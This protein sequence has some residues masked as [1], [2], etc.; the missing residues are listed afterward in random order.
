MAIRSIKNFFVGKPLETWQ[1]KQ[2]KIPKWKALAVFSSD[3]LS[4]VAY[5]TQE[6]LMALVVVSIAA[7]NWSLPIGLAIA[8]LLVVVSTSYSQ[9]IRCYPH[10]G[11]AYVVVRENLGTY[12]ALV[13]AAA[14]LIDYVLTVAVSAAAGVE[15]ITSA[16]PVLYGHRV[17]LGCIA[18][19][20][21]TTINLRG[22]RESAAVFA[23]PTYLFIFSFILLIGLGFWKL[24]AGELTARAPVFHETYSTIAPFLILK[25]FASGCA[26]LT[27]IEAISDGVPSFRPPEAR[28]ARITLFWMVVILGSFFL[29][30]TTLA[31]LFN[32]FPH[33]TQK[34]TVISQLGRLVFG[35]GG[36]YYVL[37]LS[38]ALIL[39]MAANTSFADFP[40]V[41]SFLGRDRFLPRQFGSLGDRLVFSNGIFILGFMSALLIIFFEGTTHKLIPLY[42][43]GVFL[44]FTF[45]Q[46]AM[47]RYQWREREKGWQ[48]SLLLSLSGAVVTAVVFSV[49][50]ITKFTHG[51]W[52]VFLVIPVIV[53]WFRATR[54]HYRQAG[55]QLMLVEDVNLS[56]PNK[57]VVVLPISG[58]HKGVVDAIKY[59]K[60][61]S[62]DVRIIYV[63]LDEQA[64]ERLKS[65]WTKLG[66][67]LE[68]VILKSPYRSIVGPIVEYIRSVDKE[69][70][71]DI[72]TVVIPEFVTAKW[73]QN[74][75]HNQTA[76]LIRTALMF[77]RG[78][79]ITSVRYHL[80]R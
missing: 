35:G 18:I 73:W 4:S 28:N 67:D 54:E 39:F 43:I 19:S 62:D 56:K 63:E 58:I 38:T 10:G 7:M 74:I 71:D 59:A 25:A 5:A 64:T 2:E 65:A 42:A 51:A 80:N 23:V 29:G 53:V 69:S 21:V 6:I 72:L 33:E 50:G 13:T 40:R 34:E 1:L 9:T 36:F 11:G 44:T 8:V 49:I 47:V 78:K 20:L 26:A 31:H 77:E 48:F 24:Y 70:D 60:A 15:A 68:L 52:M 41:C 30:A 57:H 46:S 3:A 17:L 76:F 27:G 55:S 32:V 75:Y 61:I 66:S 14:L 12:P 37:Q 79:V 16:I 22:M 45:S